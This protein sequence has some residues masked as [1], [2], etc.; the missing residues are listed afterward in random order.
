MNVLRSCVFAAALAISAGLV[1]SALAQADITPDVRRSAQLSTDQTALVQRFV[2]DNSG[3]LG[4]DN[5]QSVRRNRVAL[6]EQLADP[7]AS[8][9]FRV[10]FSKAL[11]PLLRPML[12][13]GA[14]M[15]IINALVL[16]GDLATGDSVALLRDAL[17]SPKPAIR[18]QA[19]FGMRR[20]FE[21]L[22]A[23]ATPTMRNDQS[24]EIVRELATRISA[25]EDAL[26]VDGLIYAGIEAARV[27]TLRSFALAR[28]AGAVATKVKA[29]TGGAGSEQLSGAL[30]R[31]SVGVRDALSSTQA[32]QTSP[33]A[34]K[35]AAELG[36]RLIAYCVRGV[37]S[38]SLP[39]AQKGEVDYVIRELYAQLATTAETIV[40]LAATLQG[41]TPPESRKIGEKL[42]ASTTISDASFGEDARLLVGRTGLLSK[43]PFSFDPGTFLD[44]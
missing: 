14:D 39:M 25:E 27:L 29:L 31:A 7:Q 19:A 37:E 4:S 38:K 10:E 43:A 30:L 9:A 18:Y 26:V 13:S 5:P 23:M 33:E 2:K 12:S 28:I 3:G 34:V 35:A 32:G 22:A 21:A 1:P 20:T 40:L 6:L 24:E 44:N 36:G 17:K 16:A 41:A 42:K 11:V 8:P 15:A